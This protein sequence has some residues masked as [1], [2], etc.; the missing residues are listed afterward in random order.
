M[1]SICDS[2]RTKR[3]SKDKIIL[4]ISLRADVRN[5]EIDACTSEK[6]ANSI[7]E[8]GGKA[9]KILCVICGLANA[10][11]VRSDGVFVVPI[12]ALKN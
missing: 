1:T 8:N 7:I 9:P 2:F 3:I 10:A 6:I 12:T 5:L 4:G 11:Y